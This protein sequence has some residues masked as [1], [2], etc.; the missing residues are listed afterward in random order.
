MTLRGIKLSFFLVFFSCTRPPNAPPDGSTPCAQA[1][2]NVR[3]HCGQKAFTPAG[4]GRCEDVCTN[5]QANGL[6][7]HTTCLAKAASCKEIETCGQ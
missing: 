6:T 4:G 3:M 7:F 1:C 5:A 2:T